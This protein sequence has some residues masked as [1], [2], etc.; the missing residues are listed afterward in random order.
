MNA[1]DREELIDVCASARVA[2]QG[3]TPAERRCFDSICCGGNGAGFAKRTIAALVEKHLVLE[4]DEQIPG[5][6]PVTVK[7][8]VVPFG[9]P[10]HIAWASLCEDEVQP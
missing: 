3:L 10:A 8:Y 1:A 5:W 6:P 4:Q 2:I 7:T 9:T